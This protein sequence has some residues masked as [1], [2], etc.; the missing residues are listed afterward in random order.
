MMADNYLPH[1]CIACGGPIRTDE[2]T[3]TGPRGVMQYRCYKR[4]KMHGR[5]VTPPDDPRMPAKEP[6]GD[7]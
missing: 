6:D 4:G 3:A 5:V 2:M 1:A 7:G